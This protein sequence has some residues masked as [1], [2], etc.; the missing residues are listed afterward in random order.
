MHRR[1]QSSDGRGSTGGHGD[2]GFK[3]IPQTRCSGGLTDVDDLSTWKYCFG[4]G[5]CDNST[6][7]CQC[8]EGYEGADCSMRSCPKG[9]AWFDMPKGDGYAHQ[10]ELTCS[11]RGSCDQISGLCQCETGFAGIAC[12]R[13][14]CGDAVNPG[15]GTKGRCLGLAKLGDVANING[16]LT[17]L[18]YGDDDKFLNG[19]DTW[20]RKMFHGCKCDGGEV[21]VNYN[22]PSSTYVSGILVESPMTLGYEGYGCHKAMCP[23]GDD[24]DTAGLNEK[25]NVTCSLTTGSFTLTFRD[26]VT[27]AIAYN[28]VASDVQAALQALTTV[29]TVTVTLNTGSA[30]VCGTGPLGFLV[31]FT[32]ETGDLPALKSNS[33]SIVTLEAVKGSKE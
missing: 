30:T 24:P 7:T 19:K 22:G 21:E 2:C 3:S 15:C 16:E 18:R 32:G 26:Q 9:T 23:Y 31:E 25:Q 20:D 27:S 10:T 5:F 13:L 1:M 4:N 33:G 28:A 8:A 11:G 17:Q 6:F 29:S 12:E 14:E